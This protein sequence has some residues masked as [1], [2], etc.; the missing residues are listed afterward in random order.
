MNRELQ[1]STFYLVYN[2][3][4]MSLFYHS[5]SPASSQIFS[6]H[7]RRVSLP[8]TDPENYMSRE[9]HYTHYQISMTTFLGFCSLLRSCLFLEWPMPDIQLFEAVPSFFQ[10][11]KINKLIPISLN[12]HV[13]WRRGRWVGSHSLNYF[14]LITVKPLY[15]W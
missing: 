14:S 10:T 2:L 4:N 15:Q 9:S 13:T 1:A 12:T 5:W 7:H 11:S 6:H 3:I 8:P